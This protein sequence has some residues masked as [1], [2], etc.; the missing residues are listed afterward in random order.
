MSVW[1][2]EAEDRLIELVKEGLKYAEIRRVM[3]GEGFAV[4]SKDSIRMKW[5]ELRD[6]AEMSLKD[7][8]AVRRARTTSNK[9]ARESRKILDGLNLADDLEARFSKLISKVKAKNFEPKN[10]T[11]RTEGVDMIVEVLLSDLHYGKKTKTFNYSV[12][13]KRMKLLAEEVIKA[14]TDKIDQGY[15]VTRIDLGMLGD[16]I[17]SSTMHGPESLKSCEFG[18][19]EQMVKAV[20]SLYHDFLE[21]VVHLGIPI[22][23]NCVPGNHERTEP[24]K[25]FHNPGRE[26]MTFVI[27]NWLKQL[28][29]KTYP[30]ADVTFNISDGPTLLHDIFGDVVLYEHFDLVKAPT[31]TALANMLAK[32]QQQLGVLVEF[33]RGGHFHESTS[34]DRGRIMANGCLPGPDDYSDAL[35]FRTE[36]SQTINFYCKTKNRPNSFY[37][38]FMPYLG[39]TNDVSK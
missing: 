28:T 39:D 8:Q 22:V 31:K 10:L 1:V 30:T 15:N 25:T 11:F 34:F 18:N 26:Y 6:E 36:A 37:Y 23:A 17:E 24:K 2:K 13:K 33:Y 38:S 27:Y 9:T 5:Y 32:R 35:G 12:A 29:A 19:S 3:L 4:K 21:P 16:I 20:D 7:R 14:V